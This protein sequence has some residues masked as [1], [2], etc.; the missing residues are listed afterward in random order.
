MKNMG[1]FC[2]FGCYE[3]MC[4]SSYHCRRRRLKAYSCYIY[5]KFSYH[6]AYMKTWLLRINAF[7]L[8]PWITLTNHHQ[9]LKFTFDLH[10]C[11]QYP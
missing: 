10:A 2:S 5:L 6:L 3:P 4:K 9:A 11:A 1:S 8:I 7:K